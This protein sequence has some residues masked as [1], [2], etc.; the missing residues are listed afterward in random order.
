M[1]LQS[2]DFS[3]KPL[4]HEVRIRNQVIYLDP[5]I[6]SA[7]QEWLSQFQEALGESDMIVSNSTENA[8]LNR[9]RMQSRSHQ[10]F[11]L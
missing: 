3:I 1:M 6:E 2:A 4:I 5:P 8:I 10:G 11:P 9:R 7:R